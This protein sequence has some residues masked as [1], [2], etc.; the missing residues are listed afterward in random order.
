MNQIASSQEIDFSMINRIKLDIGGTLFT[1]TVKTL[2]TV[3]GSFFDDMLK[4]INANNNNNCNQISSY[5][6]LQSDGSIFI[7]RSP[8]VFEHILNYLRGYT[9]SLSNLD[10]KEKRAL[11]EDSSFYNLS[12]LFESVNDAI[13]SK[14]FETE[15]LSGEEIN[16]IYKWFPN[17][18]KLNLLYRA[19]RDGYTASRF[20][21]M[22]DSKSNTLVIV[23]D[24]HGCKFGGYSPC[25]WDCSE[26]EKYDPKTFLF[27]SLNEMLHRLN[28]TNFELSTG[29]LQDISDM[30]KKTNCNETHS[31]YGDRQFGPFFGC[32]DLCIAD[33]CNLNTNSNSNSVHFQMPHTIS[34]YLCSKGKNFQ[35]L[36]VEVF[37]I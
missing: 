3:S 31:I 16:Q 21:E 6:D 22:C 8:F 5:F 9:I 27:Y 26:T 34:G 11:L 1:T 18:K 28:H 33:K 19:S 32:V 37:E 25:S 10:E 35:V 36:E 15:I 29:K 12:Q 17:T 2:R 30:K 24:S 14:T 13:N 23:K 7:D 20:H 4:K